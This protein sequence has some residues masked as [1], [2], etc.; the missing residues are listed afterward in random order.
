MYV[1]KTEKQMQDVII[2]SYSLC[3]KCGDRIKQ[4]HYDAFDFNLTYKTGTSYPEGGEGCETTVD[5][6][7]KCA[8]ELIEL[9]KEKGY[10]INQEEWDY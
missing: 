6:C 9:L 4:V 7:P 8:E 1:K 3:D 2:E 5:L 10:R